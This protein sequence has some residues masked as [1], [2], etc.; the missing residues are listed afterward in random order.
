VS[1]PVVLAV[2]A[3]AGLSPETEGVSLPEPPRPAKG[4]VAQKSVSR[5]KA[6]LL[7]FV[8]YVAVGMVLTASAWS[9][10]T[11]RWVG[12]PGDPMK[13]MDFLAWYPFALGHGL[14]PLLDTFVNLP[15]GSNMM[16]DTTMP[17]VALVLWPV[18]VT[19]GAI[20]GFNVALTGA[21]VL[22][23]W[24]S[25]LW[26]RR[27]VM[28]AGA[29]WLAG[30]A[31][32]FGPYVSAR[33]HGHLNLL[34]F[35]PVVLIIREVEGLVSRHGLERWKWSG[36]RIG[37]LAVVQLLC[38]EE[39]LALAAVILAT[40][41]VVLVLRHPQWVSRNAVAVGRAAVAACGTFL[42]G[43]SVPLGYQFFGPGR[44]VGPIQRPN[45]YVT[46][47]ENFVL[48]GVFGA[49][50]PHSMAVLSST[51]RWTGYGIE[52][53]GYIG[54]PL[55]LLSIFVVMR[56]RRD[57]WV[58]AVGVATV[59]AA[60][61]SLGPYLHIAGRT[62]GRIPLPGRLLEVL[63]VLDNVLPARF[64]LFVDLGLAALLGVFLDRVVFGDHN[65][66]RAAAAVA[67]AAACV[68]L[69]PQIPVAAT[70]P[71]TPRYFLPGGDVRSLPQGTVALVVPYGDDEQTMGPMLWQAM[72]GFR[73]RMVSGAMINAGWHGYRAIGRAVPGPLS[74]RFGCMMAALQ[75]R[76]ASI[77]TGHPVAVARSELDVLGV[78]MIIMG[79]PTFGSEAVPRGRMEH[80]LS[81]VVG[82]APRYDEGVL[83]WRY[84]PVRPIYIPQGAH[85]AGKPKD[86]KVLAVR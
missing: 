20:L 11:R 85:A 84:S 80:F 5:R 58:G 24:C 46:D 78:H 28:S 42:V 31:V 43:A 53:N 19:F 37:A 47:L 50:T 18:T 75:E 65:G 77:C 16:W 63:P 67:A 27:H 9:D 35:F 15:R 39:V 34:Y 62:Y 79:P 29:A 61:W 55:L 45:V 30:L 82:H 36:L 3:G 60:V 66:R 54:V 22:D 51:S 48:L 14:N 57:P 81:S 56:W 52:S 26:L 21:L 68:P 7:A 40:V 2:G 64:A 71:A 38:C 83:V 17:F 13:F 10:P 44:V 73:F 49:F 70:G 86:T 6:G 12:Q 59:A 72:A 1:A 23:G 33:L 25:Y 76:T 74:T 41:G 32:L 8:G 69:A 4:S